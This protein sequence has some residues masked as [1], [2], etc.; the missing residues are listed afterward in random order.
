MMSE[1]ILV[2]NEQAPQTNRFI[3]SIGALIAVASISSAFAGTYRLL[4]MK[5]VMTFFGNRNATIAAKS[6]GFV[7]VFFA[8]TGT[9]IVAA[10]L[11]RMAQR[12]H[13]SQ[14]GL[15][16]VADAVDGQGNG[17]SLPRTLLRSLATWIAISSLG[18]LG[19]ESAISEVGGSL[20]AAGARKLRLPIP[21]L[22]AAGMAAAFAAAYHAP[23]AAC[24]Y[25]LELFVKRP[26]RRLILHLMASAAISHAISI[27]VFRRASIFREADDPLTV[28]AFTRSIAV[29]LFVVVVIAIFLKLRSLLAS[30]SAKSFV[31][32]YR[33][34]AYLLTFVFASIAGATV[35]LVPLSAGNGMEAIRASLPT[36]TIGMG[37]ALAFGKLAATSASLASGAPGGMFSPAMAIGA[38]AAI[39]CIHVLQGWQLTTNTGYWDAMIPAMA[40]AVAIAMRAPFTAI[41]VVAELCGDVRVLPLTTFAVAIGVGTHWALKKIIRSKTTFRL[42]NSRT[43][44]VDSE[45]G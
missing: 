18:S 40:V 22:A 23:F 15:S 29:A 37:L 17:P 43:V 45:S 14:L 13:T 10:F 27:G 16:A 39:V 11:G 2:N 31:Q 6:H 28:E 26:R 33:M 24:L 35:A 1:R 34:R 8:V 19:R 7:P 5:A 36:T 38:G 9:L 32:P 30:F 4:A 25:V 21:D 41:V 42:P 44:T 20:G 12:S 3:V